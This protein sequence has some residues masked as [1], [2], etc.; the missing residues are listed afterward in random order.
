MCDV[1]TVQEGLSV[2]ASFVE[3][4]LNADFTRQK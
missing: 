1:P 3:Y 2:N 4:S